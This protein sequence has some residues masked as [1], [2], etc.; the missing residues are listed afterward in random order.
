MHDKI[1][2]IGALALLSLAYGCKD[3]EFPVTVRYAV[4]I[5]KEDNSKLESAS[6]TSLHERLMSDLQNEG[7]SLCMDKT[8]DLDKEYETTVAGNDADVKAKYSELDDVMARIKE[9][10]DLQAASGQ[11]GNGSINVK[12]TISAERATNWDEIPVALGGPKTYAFEYN[13]PKIPSDAEDVSANGTANCYIVKPGSRVYFTADRMGNSTET[14]ISGASDAILVW[15]DA[16]GLVG[17]IFLDGNKVFVLANEGVEGNA[18]VAV[19]DASGKI[20]WSWHLWVTDY[21][22]AESIFS[23]PETTNGTV[24]KMMDRN[25][26]ALSNSS[27]S[28]ESRGLM[29]QWGRKD[30]FPG[31]AGFTAQNED[32]SYITDGEKQLY[33]IEG[34]PI[35]K[36]FYATAQGY[37]TLALSIEHPDVFYKV[38]TSDNAFGHDYPS[39]DWKKESDDDSWGGVSGK[40]TMYDPCPSG[41]KVPALDSHDASPFD[42]M[43]YANATF[44]ENPGAIQNGQWFPFCGSRVNYSGGLDF[45]EVRT[46]GGYWLA[47]H[48]KASDDLEQFP[49]L[50]GQ[51]IYL[52]QNRRMFGR[53]MKDSRSQCLSVRCVAE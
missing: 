48:G 49:T 37:G 28:P 5:E 8:I 31:P 47:N 27:E 41:Y 53:H 19:T 34:V 18:L 32:Y 14:N 23:T 4:Q 39:M 43:S 1:F 52:Y 15:Q 44:S 24:W 26:G 50:Y 42:W 12:C 46:Y 38:V 13:G 11:Y 10:F 16:N 51:Y 33:D 7:F 17:N 36:K 45:P 30:P 3:D 20:L 22:P 21:S 6:V 9:T 29:Y 40:K 25:I 35:E 2:F